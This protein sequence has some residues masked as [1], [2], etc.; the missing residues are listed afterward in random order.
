MQEEAYTTP[1][2][3]MDNIPQLFYAYIKLIYSPDSPIVRD[4]PDLA[5]RKAQ[6]AKRTG[7]D[8]VF[9]H[10]EAAKYIISLNNM[11]WTEIVSNETAFEEYT[12]R[13][14][15]PLSDELDE[16]KLL[17]AVTVKSTM[18]TQMGDI[19]KRITTLRNEMFHSDE[20]LV[21]T[22][23]SIKDFTAEAVAGI[24]ISKK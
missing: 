23:R 17:K 11:L 22:H 7:C 3:Y 21:E 15:K 10:K 18:L 5:E 12:L 9:F 2:T 24:K 8:G 13:V 6:A 19:R 20:E 14:N 1:T 16:D 4:F